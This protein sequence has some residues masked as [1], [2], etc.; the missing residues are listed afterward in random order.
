MR[1]EIGKYYFNEKRDLLYVFGEGG[2]AE[3]GS[4][5]YPIGIKEEDVK[6]ML[7]ISVL[8]FITKKDF[9]QFQ[10][11]VHIETVFK[12]DN[13]TVYDGEWIETVPTSDIK[14]RFEKTFRFMNLVR[15]FVNHMES[16]YGEK[17]KNEEICVREIL[18]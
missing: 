13:D 5:T 11:S 8:P 16:V 9:L 17:Y 15:I 2:M 1:I 10:Q 14:S 18:K 12:I 3:T 4:L 6:A 7:A